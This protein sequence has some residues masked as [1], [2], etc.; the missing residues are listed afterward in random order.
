MDKKKLMQD[1]FKARRMNGLDIS[2]IIGEPED[3]PS[4]DGEMPEGMDGGMEEDKRAQELGLAPEA[5]VI[6]EKGEDSELPPE[7][8]LSDMENSDMPQEDG[9]D[10][11]SLI[12]S[13]LAKSGL[14][15]SSLF[16]KTKARKASL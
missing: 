12:E 7:E 10:N 4:E 5:S 6:K 3:E 13:E 15:K 9:M 16:G 2:I 14:G 11:Q 8:M 1:A